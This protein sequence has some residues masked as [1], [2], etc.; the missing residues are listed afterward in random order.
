MIIT[1][2]IYKI[3]NMKCL[4]VLGLLPLLL[5]TPKETGELRRIYVFFS[6]L[7]MSNET[8][9]ISGQFYTTDGT[10]YKITGT[11]LKS[12]GLSKQNI[13]TRLWY[14]DIPKNVQ[15]S[16]FSVYYK[17]NQLWSTTNLCKIKGCTFEYSTNNYS[18]I[19]DN[20]GWHNITIKTD[21]FADYFLSRINTENNSL[22]DGYMAYKYLNDSIFVSLNDYD[23]EKE[24]TIRWKDDFLG[25]ITF[26][27]KWDYI[28]TEYIANYQ[29]E[30]KQIWPYFIGSGLI[31]WASAL[32]YLFIF[33][34][35][36]N[37]KNKK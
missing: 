27:Q 11:M 26:K 18:N 29:N 17:G 1:N 14:L 12:N 9:T 16:I 32:S 10:E 22:T 15:T 19:N 8:F 37:G 31:L 33:K 7:P 20:T 21:Q 6:D 34:G 13:D 24:N 36:K 4:L 35:W 30:K 3:V 28:K 5:S 2:R 23:T 25:Y